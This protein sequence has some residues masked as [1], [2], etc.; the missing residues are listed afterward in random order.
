MR[1]LEEKIINVIAKNMEISVSD[2][3]LWSKL[4]NDLGMDSLDIIETTL[5]IEE[6]FKISLNDTDINKLK[7]VNDF[8]E[9]VKYK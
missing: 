1:S 6:C 5:K 8:V 3:F 2:V 7:I 9:I 4:V